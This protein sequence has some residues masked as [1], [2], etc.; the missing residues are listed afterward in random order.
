MTFRDL[1]ERTG[2]SREQIAQE[3]GVKEKTV[4]KW[5]NSE[6]VPSL[7]KIDL[8]VIAYKSDYKTILEV[9]KTHS[10][11]RIMRNRHVTM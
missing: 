1:R 6:R 9:I 7:K 11:T 4:Y 5:E 8:L 3:V 2:K 10:M